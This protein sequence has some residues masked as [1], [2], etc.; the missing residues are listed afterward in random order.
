[1]GSKR[2]VG[3]REEVWE[4]ERLELLS[5]CLC[6]WGHCLSEV[7]L[8]VGDMRNV[9]HPPETTPS[10][11]PSFYLQAVGYLTTALCPPPSAYLH[12]AGSHFRERHYCY[13]I[14]VTN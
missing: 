11:P 13:T 2:S 8:F 3:K 12:Q 10:L 4:K 9:A 5:L 1:M 14:Y 7:P 6:L